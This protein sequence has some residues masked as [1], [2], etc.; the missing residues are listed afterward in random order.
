MRFVL[1]VIAGILLWLAPQSAAQEPPRAALAFDIA[2]VKPSAG[3]RSLLPTV[4]GR[5]LIA[6]NVPLRP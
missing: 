5:Q 6:T 3:G 1:R 4:Q 2:S